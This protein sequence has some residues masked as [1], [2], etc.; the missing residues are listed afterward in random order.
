MINFSVLKR[1]KKKNSCKKETFLWLLAFF[2]VIIEI[3][4]TKDFGIKV[5]SFLKNNNL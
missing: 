5:E 2:D 1:K 4:M 3:I